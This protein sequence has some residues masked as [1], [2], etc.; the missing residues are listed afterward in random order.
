MA[1]LAMHQGLV[2]PISLPSQLLPLS[3]LNLLRGTI[4]DLLKP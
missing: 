2:A 3:R 1:R 4:S